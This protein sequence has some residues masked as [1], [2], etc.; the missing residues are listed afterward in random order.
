MWHPN[1]S[2]HNE[3]L[4][5]I[6]TMNPLAKVGP[7]EKKQKGKVRSG[8]TNSSNQRRAGTRFSNN[9]NLQTQS[10]VPTQPSPVSGVAVGPMP[11]PVSAS[12]SLGIGNI[13]SPSLN[14]IG[15]PGNI[16]VAPPINQPSQGQT[17]SYRNTK[18]I[19]IDRSKFHPSIS[20]LAGA[21][22]G[23]SGSNQ[24]WMEQESGAQVQILGTTGNDPEGLHILV[25]YNEPRELE[26]VEA[27]I[28]EIGRATFEGG[29]GF[30]SHI[31]PNRKPVSPT[32]TGLQGNMIVS[33]ALQDHTS[34][35]EK[36]I[37]GSGVA[38]GG[39]PSLP[40]NYSSSQPLYNNMSSNIGMG[41]I[42][43]G[44]IVAPIQIEWPKTP[45]ASPVEFEWLLHLVLHS[46]L[47]QLGP[48]VSHGVPMIHIPMLYDSFTSFR[49]EHDATSFFQSC[50]IQN[51][52]L[53]LIQALPHIFI[54]GPHTIIDSSNIPKLSPIFKVNLSSGVTPLLLPAQSVTVS[55]ADFKLAA[56]A[57]WKMG[58]LPP[59]FSGFGPQ[60]PQNING[61]SGP[62]GLAVTGSTGTISDHVYNTS[63]VVSP[64]QSARQH[65]G[66]DSSGSSIGENVLAG[67]TNKIKKDQGANSIINTNSNQ[68]TKGSSLISDD[69][70]TFG[71]DNSSSKNGVIT[72]GTSSVA[73]SSHSS[74]TT[75]SS[76][77]TSI[78]NVGKDNIPQTSLM[79]V[80]QGV[81]FLLR[82]WISK[83]LAPH[84]IPKSSLD[85]L[86]LDILESEFSQFYE[87][88][89]NIEILGWTNLL[90]FVEA[91]PDVWTVENVGPDEFTLIPL[92]YPDFSMIAKTRGITK[93][94]NEKHY[95]SKPDSNAFT[96]SAQGSSLANI[97]KS[98]GSLDNIQKIVKQTQDFVAEAIASGYPANSLEIN[99]INEIINGV[100]MGIYSLDNNTSSSL[101]ELVTKVTNLLP[102]YS[103]NS[104]SSTSTNFPNKPISGSISKSRFDNAYKGTN[105]IGS[106]NGLAK[107]TKSGGFQHQPHSLQPPTAYPSTHISLANE[108]SILGGSGNH[109]SLTVPQ[110]GAS[111]F[112][113]MNNAKNEIRY[114]IGA[115]QP[116][117]THN[118]HN[119]HLHAPHQT[120]AQVLNSNLSTGRSVNGGQ[121]KRVFSN[122][123]AG[124]SKGPKQ[125]VGQDQRPY[126]LY[127]QQGSNPSTEFVNLQHNP[128]HMNPTQNT[129]GM[130]EASESN[131]HNFYHHSMDGNSHFSTYN[132][133]GIS[134]IGNSMAASCHYDYHSFGV[135]STN[136]AFVQPSQNH[137]MNGA[138]FSKSVGIPSDQTI[139]NNGNNNGNNIMLSLPNHASVVSNRSGW[140]RKNKSKNN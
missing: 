135:Q 108:K 128:N 19:P 41:F 82:R 109:H 83:R 105:G 79:I 114:D 87:I 23:V 64:N 70:D 124:A 39:M 17:V 92:P 67:G 77:V 58:A 131:I 129:F 99:S 72:N 42:P 91:F 45:P 119:I 86:P 36:Q 75:T 11:I 125:L 88:P 106:M 43:R 98:G 85:F 118:Q 104:A 16:V 55:F 103:S 134:S 9:P 35:I 73:L 60:V 116:M 32:L 90:H 122:Q 96:L 21:I 48:M 28:E 63:S 2:G 40:P 112:N 62:S 12:N 81:H 59:T 107:G 123:C 100:T 6:S 89:L 53:G 29:G 69:D 15:V 110:V 20:N 5:T 130:Q 57:F 97:H 132:G 137:S 94:N 66:K 71:I 113:S 8:P 52:L 51:G 25:R 136:S 49:F 121:S 93:L 33:A 95:D 140:D 139:G 13:N 78:V 127:D 27:I 68:P 117:S 61:T 3:G 26:I 74:T 1:V 50:I 54:E 38:M 133:G 101:Y 47:S 34:G 44:N 46:A 18:K 120:N 111:R 37:M 22:I 14:S 102:K 84:Y 80:L 7:T 10:H 30:I 76:G 24:K 65:Q 138:H 126:P 31:L 56:E 4:E 115:A